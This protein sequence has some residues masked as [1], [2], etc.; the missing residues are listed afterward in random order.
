MLSTVSASSYLAGRGLLPESCI[1]NLPIVTSLG[2]GVSSVVLLVECG[3]ERLVVKQPRE[4]LLVADQWLAKRERAL[5]EAA[6]LRFARRSAPSEVPELLDIDGQTCT[7]TMRAAPAGWR[8]WKELLLA[9]HIDPSVGWRLGVLLG[10]W[11]C[12]A[13]YPESDLFELD[14][15]QIF[16]QL[17][18]NP[19]HRKVAARHPG[20][21]PEIEG[22]IDEL[23]NGG[24]F[25]CFVHGD[26]SPKNVLV[27]NGGLFVIDFEVAHIGNPL[28]D[29]A[30]LITHLML[31]SVRSPAMAES[32][33]QCA[34]FFIQGYMS[35]KGADRVPLEERL[36]LQVGCLLLARVHG[37][38]PVEYLDLSQQREVAEL[39]TS[40]VCSPTDPF[41]VWPGL[42][43]P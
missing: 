29:L 40:L 37:K 25:R 11:H 41:R 9:G 43:A 15:L 35:V 2:G 18:I 36:G 28:F 3:A 20:L 7:I 19:F 21:A 1:D 23:V 38:S 10:T 32:Y 17:R 22:A 5:I 30:F 12:L 14:D 8:P 31:K 4:R 26:F 13:G 34:Q 42:T 39:G 24:A 33:R 27:G 16:E 6:A